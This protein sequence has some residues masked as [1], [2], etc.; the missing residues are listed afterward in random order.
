MFKSAALATFAIAASAINLEAESFAESE[1]V[2]DEAI[3]NDSSYGADSID[4]CRLS[5]V[6]GEFKTAVDYRECVRK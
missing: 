2:L 4:E 3:C 5:A 6:Y 1:V